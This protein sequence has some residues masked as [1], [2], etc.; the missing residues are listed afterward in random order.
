MLNR[1]NLFLVGLL[2]IQID[3]ARRHRGDEHG[4]GSAGDRKHRREY[5]R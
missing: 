5:E 2:V 3:R 1:N 4:F